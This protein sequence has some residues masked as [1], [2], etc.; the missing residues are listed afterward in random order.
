MSKIHLFSLI[1]VKRKVTNF[2]KRMVDLCV[3]ICGLT[4]KSPSYLFS[5]NFRQLI[6]LKTKI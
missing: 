5:V 4:R 1:V 3:F 6:S 2:T